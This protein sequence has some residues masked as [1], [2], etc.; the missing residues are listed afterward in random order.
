[1]L[2]KPIL[3]S[4]IVARSLHA[5]HAAPCAPG[6]GVSEAYFAN[7]FISLQVCVSAHVIPDCSA[8]I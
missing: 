5:T 3:H 6:G 4:L 1:M 8:E 7:T 2:N